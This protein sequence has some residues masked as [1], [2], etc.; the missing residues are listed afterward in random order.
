MKEWSKII[1]RHDTNKQGPLRKTITITTN[2]KA[3]PILALKI[4]GIVLQK[5]W[6]SKN[7]INFIFKKNRIFFIGF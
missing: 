2:V 3:N 4:K 6:V 5:S 1:I 7:D